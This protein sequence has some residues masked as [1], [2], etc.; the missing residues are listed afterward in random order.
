M[1]SYA[2]V[3]DVAISRDVS[4][5]VSEAITSS[6]LVKVPENVTEFVG[7]ANTGYNGVPVMNSSYISSF[8][9]MGNYTGV[10][11]LQLIGSN[12]GIVY[13]DHNLTV[14]STTSKFLQFNT[15]FNST[16]SPDGE[17]EWRLTFDGSKVAG[18]SLN[19][20]YMQLFPP[21][22]HDRENGLRHDVATVLE[23][24]RLSFLRF[25]GGN[26]IEGFQ[27]D[28]RWKW[29]TTIGPLINR[30]GRESDWSYPNTDALG[31]DEYLWWC[32]DM[33]MTPVLAVWAGKSYG[34]IL[35]GS[36][37][38]PYV[39]DIMNELEYLLGDT[40]TENGKVRAENGRKESWKID[41]LEIGNEDDLSGGCS[42]YAERFSQIYK[43]IHEKY[44]HMTIIASNGDSSCLPSPV[45]K[46]VILDLHLYRQPDEFVA[47][48]DQFDHQPRDQPVMIGEYA[49]RNITNAKGTYWSFMQGTC[50]EAVYMIG[51]ERNSDIVK[52]A[53][54]AP[55]LEHFEF[56]SW[57]VRIPYMQNGVGLYPIHD[58][59]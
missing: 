11:N 52:M 12:G 48:F 34:E 17:N 37:L 7:F 28:S 9:M 18:D 22:Y 14:N 33:K 54:Y 51:M 16:S 3:G 56:I 31:L 35:S 26:N 41:Y 2:P 8:W 5:P 23:E 55:M 20:G 15:S 13:A 19:F 25:P 43:A 24:T 30:P 10:V 32:E 39:E 21:T 6:L 49:C 50:S 45:P 27:V 44:P 1:T 58:C 29:N 57:S 38:D 46:G 53:A 40:E 47:L 59:R 36:K 42:T 4:K